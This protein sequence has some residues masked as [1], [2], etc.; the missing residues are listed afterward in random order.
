M[1]TSRNVTRE[2]LKGRI[3]AG[4]HGLP[5]Q[6]CVVLPDLLTENFIGEFRHEQLPRN[7]SWV[8]APWRP[9]L[10]LVRRAM[11]CMITE[12]LGGIEL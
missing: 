8:W 12:C 6:F 4:S 10:V 3:L 1:L 5:K 2:F 9:W 11:E 7:C